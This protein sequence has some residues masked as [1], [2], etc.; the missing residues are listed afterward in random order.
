[1]KMCFHGNRLL[2][3]TKHP[4]IS[5]Y[6]K[7]LPWLYLSFHNACP[8]HLKSRRDLLYL[9]LFFYKCSVLRYFTPGFVCPSN[10][11]LFFYVFVVF[12]LTAAQMLL[13]SQIQP[14]P[15]YMR[16]PLLCIWPCFLMNHYQHF[17]IL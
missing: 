11:F 5:L 1:M 7:L 4:I 2:W 8:C 6:F 10:H 17:M 9:L 15:T 12:G 16:L 13:S 3:G 14:L